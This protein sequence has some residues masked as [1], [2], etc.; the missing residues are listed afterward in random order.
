VCEW[1]E[2][3]ETGE[4]IIHF[5]ED[6]RLSNLTFF[7]KVRLWLELKSR[8]PRLE[9]ELAIYKYGVEAEA[10]KKAVMML[11]SIGVIEQNSVSPLPVG[12][13]IIKGGD[14]EKMAVV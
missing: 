9:E 8:L 12:R 2:E 3:T 11:E 10:T 6:P 13:K 5:S 14:P 7:T 4:R 1:F